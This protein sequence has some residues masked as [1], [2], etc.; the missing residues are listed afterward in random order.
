MKTGKFHFVTLFCLLVAL[1]LGATGQVTSFE[2]TWRLNRDKSED[3]SGGLHGAEMLLEV[4]QTHLELTV[5]EKIKIRGRVQPSQPRQFRLDGRES[6]VEVSRP[7]AGTMELEARLIAR[8][9]SLQLKSTIS[10]DNQGE[11]V[12]L[13]TKEYWELTDNGKTLKITRLR[14]L[15]EKSQQ[16]VLIFDKQ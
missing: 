11:P 7:L 5:E 15:G 16:S 3:L 13:I 4:T 1:Q 10:G 8:G 9:R 14:E 12:T 6:T 2:G